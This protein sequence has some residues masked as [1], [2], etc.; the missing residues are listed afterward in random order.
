MGIW[1]HL[2]MYLNSTMGLAVAIFMQ[3]W[4]LTHSYGAGEKEE[5]PL[6]LSIL[7]HNNSDQELCLIK[8][9]R[10]APNTVS[11]TWWV[12]ISFNKSEF[13]TVL[14]SL[15]KTVARERKCTLSTWPGFLS[16]F[17]FLLCVP[18]FPWLRFFPP[19]YFPLFIFFPILYEEKL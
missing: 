8:K 10:I 14:V 2:K 5:V 17:V 12:I 19:P 3:Q 18:F 15:F 9:E 16:I 4:H 11:W 13:V 7:L 1:R 6:M